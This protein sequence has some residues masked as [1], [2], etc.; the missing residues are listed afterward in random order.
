MKKNAFTLIELVVALAIF[1]LVIS[2]VLTL[3]GMGIRGQ[4]KVI[5][6]QNVEDNARYLLGFMAKE[7]RMSTINS[8][9]ATTLNITRPDGEEV[10]YFFKSSNQRIQR[11]GQAINSNEVLVTGSFSGLGIGTG[12]EQQARITIV[13]KIE[14]TGSKAEEKAEVEVQITL[15]PRNLES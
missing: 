10:E 8:V 4:R 13:M 12:D 9:S 6:L 7:I 5:A 3:F 14:T 2:L 11:N 1:I 15:N